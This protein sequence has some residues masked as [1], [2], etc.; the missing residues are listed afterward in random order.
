M[1]T[2]PSGF[3]YTQY[4]RWRESH[5]SIKAGRRKYFFKRFY[6]LIFR[7]GK[8]KEEERER[9]IN[10]RETSISCLLHI[11]NWG[12]GPQPRHEPWQRIEPATLQITGQCSIHW[13][14]PARAKVFSWRDG[15]VVKFVYKR[16]KMLRDDQVENVLQ[17]ISSGKR[18]KRQEQQFTP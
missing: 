18:R 5:V 2:L 7:K 8:G 17:S 11:P 16:T 4:K 14:T 10:M 13:A 3:W 6:L 1:K 9:N 12:P 15:V